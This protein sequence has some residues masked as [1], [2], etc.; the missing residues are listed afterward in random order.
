MRGTNGWP[1]SY[2]RFL[3]A[4]TVVLLAEAA[5]FYSASR[6]EK[7]PVIPSLQLFPYGMSGWM[8]IRETPLEP[9]V[10]E[11]LRADDALNRSYQNQTTGA[12]VF[13]FVAYFR[14]QRSGQ[15]PHSP[16]NCLPGSGWEQ[17][18]SGYTDVNIP[19]QPQPLTVNRYVVGHGTD[20]SVVLYWYQSPRRVVAN[21][22]AAKFWLVADSIR[23]HRSD[24]AVVRVVVPVREDDIEAAARTGVSFVQTVFP[25]LRLHLGM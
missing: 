5:L 6:G 19:G 16:K 12:L 21:E 8:T 20:K 24:T 7:V 23:Y 3:R 22:F 2:N 10:Q 17:I 15:T 11:V 18:A 25:P 9:E 1:P 13:L 4:L 14:S